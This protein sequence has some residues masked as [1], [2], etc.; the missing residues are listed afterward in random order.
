MRN[1]FPDLFLFLSITDTSFQNVVSLLS[2]AQ[3]LTGKC[4]AGSTKT[5]KVTGSGASSACDKAA[6]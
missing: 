1:R 3:I 2:Y 5:R 4:V 6:G